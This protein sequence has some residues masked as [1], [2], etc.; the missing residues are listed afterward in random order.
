MID[1]GEN[2]TEESPMRDLLCW[3]K[4]CLREAQMDEQTIYQLTGVSG[5][6][7]DTRL[8]QLIPGT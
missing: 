8:S 3:K 5:K 6:K 2:S 7:L 4:L 1:G